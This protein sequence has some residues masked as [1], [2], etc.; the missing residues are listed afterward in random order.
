MP[1]G[2]WNERQRIF[3]FFQGRAKG[4]HRGPT[5]RLP[6]GRRCQPSHIDKKGRCVNCLDWEKEGRPHIDG[7]PSCPYCDAKWVGRIRADVGNEVN[8]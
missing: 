6:L 1:K 8:P 4:S 2:K 7:M 5:N 3:S